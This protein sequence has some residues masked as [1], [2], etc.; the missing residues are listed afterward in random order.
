MKIFGIG[1]NYVEHA[2]E[3]DNEVPSEPVLFLM[4]E[5]AILRKNNPFYIPDFS[6]DIHYEVELVLKIT[7]E[8]KNVEEKFAHKYYDTIG[9]GVDFTARDLQ[10]AAKSKGLPW[11]IAKGFYGSLP[12]SE[13][14]NKEKLDLSSINFSLL[15]NEEVV[16]SGDSKNMIFSFEAII[17]Y[18]SQ[19]FLLKKGDLIYTGTP[20]GVGK[21]KIGD[22]LKGVL[23]DKIMFDFEIK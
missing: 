12:I 19:F 14:V 2:K 20:A 15:K 13:F 5:T 9:L 4:P 11:S 21:V 10:S 16:Q 8:G 22:R 7:K 6:D 3:L 1:R 17:A 18:V 23:E